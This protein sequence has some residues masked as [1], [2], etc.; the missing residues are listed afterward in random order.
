MKIKDRK[1]PYGFKVRIIV[2]GEPGSGKS[3]ILNLIYHAL[4]QQKYPI[5]L[6]YAY[7]YEIATRMKD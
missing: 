4:K 3:V 2:T 6:D 7:E 1:L 5:A